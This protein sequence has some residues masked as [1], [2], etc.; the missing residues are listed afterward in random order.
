MPNPP[1]DS[2]DEDLPLSIEL[3][4]LYE[5]FVEHHSNCTFLFDAVTCMLNSNTEM[6][7]VAVEGLSSLSW[8]MRRK[9]GE[10]K[11]EFKRL[12]QKSRELEAICKRLH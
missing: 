3:L 4:N 11:E 2:A 12:H 1:Q 6:D 10:L 8:Q 7:P 9:A 5:E